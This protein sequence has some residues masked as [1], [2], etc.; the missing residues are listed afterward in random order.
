MSADL[1][2]TF[3]VGNP[4]INHDPELVKDDATITKNET[5]E[6]TIM[7]VEDLTM[8]D[9]EEVFLVQLESTDTNGADIINKLPAEL[10]EGF[11]E[12]VSN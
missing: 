6:S 2:K 8:G 7:A 9:V 1:D 11:K 4:I 10:Q 5:F 3:L 12:T